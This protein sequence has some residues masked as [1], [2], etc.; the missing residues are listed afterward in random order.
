M[1]LKEYEHH[2]NWHSQCDIVDV[3]SDEVQVE[4]AQKGGFAIHPIGDKVRL[5]AQVIFS[6][7]LQSY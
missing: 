3:T 5:Q 1:Y 2:C 4:I 6:A 7:C